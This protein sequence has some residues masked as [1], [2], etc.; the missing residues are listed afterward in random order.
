MCDTHLS[1]LRGERGRERGRRKP[2][3]PARRDL[4]K[5]KMVMKKV[6]VKWRSAYWL[7]SVV[8]DTKILSSWSWLAYSAGVLLV[9]ASVIS[10][11]SFIRPAMFDLQLEWT[12]GVGGKGRAK[13]SHYIP[14]PLLI[15]D[16]QPPPW[17]KFIS[18]PSLPL[19]LKS[20]TTAIIY[21]MKLLSTRSPK[22]RL[23]CRLG[24]DECG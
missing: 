3:D 22:L 19:L 16:R 12:V 5:K 4:R 18:L 23:L 1:V 2:F 10:S 24:L 8:L 14:T 15:F 6:T 21:V 11:R 20:K 17:Y 9:R 13:R 7:I